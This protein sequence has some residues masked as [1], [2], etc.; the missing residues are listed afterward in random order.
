MYIEAHENINQIFEERKSRSSKENIYSLGLQSLAYADDVALLGR[1]T[2]DM[3][4]TFT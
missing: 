4:K 2:C 3:D 1:D